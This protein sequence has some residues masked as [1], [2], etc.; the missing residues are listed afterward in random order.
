MTL[1]EWVTLGIAIGTTVVPIVAIVVGHWLIRGRRA[2][3]QRA[4]AEATDLAERRAQRLR[5]E[6]RRD[7]MWAQARRQLA[8]D[9]AEDPCP[10]RVSSVA[11]APACRGLVVIP[12]GR[13]GWATAMAAAASRN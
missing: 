4:R 2:P 10:Q 13:G 12:G 8:A 1:T 3:W 9:R 6:A 5:W 7:L 11:Y